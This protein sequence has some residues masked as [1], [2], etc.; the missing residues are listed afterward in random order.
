MIGEDRVHC[1]LVI[2]KARVARTGVVTILGLKL[3]AAVVFAAVGNMLK[4]VIEL[5]FGR[6]YFWTNSRVVLD[7]INNEARR[8]H[9]F[10]A[11]S[12]EESEERLTQCNGTM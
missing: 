1:A 11:N 2:G 12:A 6:E 9:V 8:F 7:Y 10:V 3:A 5:R 4:E